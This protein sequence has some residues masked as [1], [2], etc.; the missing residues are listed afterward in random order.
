MSETSSNLQF[1]HFSG[2]SIGF[3]YNFVLNDNDLYFAHL[4]NIS[5]VPSLLEKSKIIFSHNVVYV[6]IL[7]AVLTVISKSV[8]ECISGVHVGL[9]STHVLF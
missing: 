9:K 6:D 4:C 1:R 8:S 2:C 5:D 3:F 7:Y